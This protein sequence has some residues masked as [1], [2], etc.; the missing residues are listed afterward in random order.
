MRIVLT[1]TSISCVLFGQAGAE[2]WIPPKSLDQLPVNRELPDLLT[3]ADG[4]RVATRDDWLQ[5][6]RELKEIVQYYQYGRIPPRPDQVIAAQQQ[7]RPLPD[8]LGREELMTLIIDSELQLRMRIALYVPKRSGPLPV[9]IREEAALGHLQEVPELMQRGYLFVEFARDD[10]DPD[11]ADTVGPAQQAYPD[12]DWATL[13]VW[14]WAG[15][16]SSTTWSRVTTLTGNESV[17]LVTRTVARPRCW[18]A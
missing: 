10:L 17:L 14:A 1:L 15:M 18:P 5:R 3:F 7:V 8:G 2:D 9:I 13:A 16:E 12:S 11:Q 4:R 6:R